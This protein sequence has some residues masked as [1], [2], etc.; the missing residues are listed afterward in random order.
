MRASTVVVSAA[1]V[2]F[3]ATPSRSDFVGDTAACFKVRD[4]AVRGRFRT[5]LT[6]N[7]QT[8]VVKLPARF[9]CFATAL[10]DTTAGGVRGATNADT[11]LCYPLRCPRPLPPGRIVT[12][13]LGGV[14]SINV[15]GAQ[16]LC[17]TATTNATVTTT[18]PS[19]SSTSSTNPLVPG[20]C[21]FR[22]GECRGTCA[23]G[24]RCGA[25]VGT[26]SCECRAVGCGQADTPTC[27][28][29]C[30]SGGDAC[31]FNPLDNSCDCVDIP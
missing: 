1:L 27:N 6:L 29:T 12:D 16:W 14:R 25:A 31:V 30:P 7:G 3:S 17:T 13:A 11:L 10:T 22:D 28:G 18:T 24:Q 9:A 19:S 23:A 2:F 4:S 8:C 5:K 21:E 20:A 15:R 26:G